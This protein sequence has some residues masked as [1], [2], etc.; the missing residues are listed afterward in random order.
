MD[1]VSPAALAATPER[2][3][4]EEQGSTDCDKLLRHVQ[5]EGLATATLVGVEGDLP[6]HVLAILQS[7][8]RSELDIRLAYRRGVGRIVR[9][10]RP[11]GISTK[12]GRRLSLLPLERCTKVYLDGCEWPLE[13]ADLSLEESTSISNRTKRAEVSVQIGTGTA[14]LFL[15]FPEEEMP[16]W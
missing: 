16:V 9:P 4:L 5:R 10:N 3:L 6:D 13:N 11:L 15:E 12:P 2:V 8:A 14:F 1:S 7:A